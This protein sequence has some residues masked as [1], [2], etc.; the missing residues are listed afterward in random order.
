M[1]S[2]RRINMDWKKMA[3][4]GLIVLAV[5]FGFVAIG[6][7]VMDFSSTTTEEGKKGQ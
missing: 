4:V 6:S 7:N 5:I 2:K 1:L 3:L